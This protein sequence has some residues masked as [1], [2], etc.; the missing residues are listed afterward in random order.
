[1]ITC[2]LQIVGQLLDARFVADRW[3]GIRRTGRRIGGIIAAPAVNIV[4]PLGLRIV[5]LQIVVADRP[6]RRHAV[7]GAMRG[8]I[9][10]AQP[11]QRRSIHLGRAAD[12]VMRPGLKRFA[13]LVIP[14]V[15]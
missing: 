13:V 12:K 11:E 7:S 2:A 1:M 15:L 9:F 5:G 6:V 14:G 3:K 10:L 8:K 4:E